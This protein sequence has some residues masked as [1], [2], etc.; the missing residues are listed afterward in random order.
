MAAYQKKN[1]VVWLLL[2]FGNFGM[3]NIYM[4]A[5]FGVGFHICSPLAGS[6]VHAGSSVLQGRANTTED[7]ACRLRM[8][9]GIA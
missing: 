7:Y 1:M 5:L 6:S 9:K 4:H 3:F 2:V 8:P